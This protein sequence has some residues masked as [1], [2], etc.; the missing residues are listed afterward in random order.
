MMARYDLKGRY[1]LITGASSGIGKELSRC[2]A[3]AG[4]QCVLHAIPDDKIILAAWAKELAKTYSVKTWSLVENFIDPDGPRR[5]HREVMKIVPHLDVLVNNAGMIQYGNFWEAPTDRLDAL[6]RVNAGAYMAL[7]R[8]FMPGMVARG[9]GRVFNVSSAAAF[10]PCPHHAL[11]G[12]AKSMVQ[13][14]S[15]AVN[16]E[17]KGTGV[18]ITTLCPSYTDTPL[19]KVNGFPEKVWWYRI[20]GLSDPADIARKGVKALVKGKVIYIPGLINK[21][22]HLVLNRITPRRLLE[23]IADFGLSSAD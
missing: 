17:L 21:F 3:G 20:S 22:V 19:L 2:I 7:M 12:A 1:V 13:S 18:K 9:E 14:L 5:L 4:A 16:R 11:Y 8:L 15:E 10:Q 6:L 23:V